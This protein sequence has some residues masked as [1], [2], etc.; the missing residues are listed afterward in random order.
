MLPR[1]DRDPL[2][3]RVSTAACRSGALL[4]DVSGIADDW[5]F[6]GSWEKRGRGSSARD[7]DRWFGRACQN[8]WARA[9]MF[10]NI[11]RSMAHFL[12]LSR[13]TGDHLQRMY[14]I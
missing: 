1:R 6:Y 11:H 12:I 9:R 5:L 10:H 7:A 8:M 2:F 4:L 13:H 3:L 14:T